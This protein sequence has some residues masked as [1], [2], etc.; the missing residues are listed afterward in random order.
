MLTAWGDESG[1]SATRDPG[2]Y[3]LGAV[4]IDDKDL[5]FARRQ[6]QK[7]KL[8]AETKAHWY[9][10]SD[11]NRA[12]VTNL[13]ASLPVH[14]IVVVRLAL[15]SERVERRRR[16]CLEFLLPT[17]T[18]E[19]CERLV[20]ESRGK[21]DDQRDRD[22]VDV[23]RAQRR[24]GTALKLEHTS[25]PREPMLWLADALCGATVAERL[26]DP[27]WWEVVKEVGTVHTIDARL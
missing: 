27:R 26:G 11:A 8:P 1:S 10:S 18:V 19:G 2:T 24:L 21:K 23:L 16:K 6:A 7:L 14:A 3:V 25:G 9:T 12:K 5:D 15:E 4:V 17:L 13:I 22:L 20:L